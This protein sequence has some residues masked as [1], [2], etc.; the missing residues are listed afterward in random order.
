MAQSPSVDEQQKRTR[1]RGRALEADI[2]KAAWLELGEL[3]WAGFRLDRV[4]A[5]A[6]TG[7]TSVYSRWPDKGSLVRDAGR[8]AAATIRESTLSGE[9]QQDLLA[10]LRG[11]ARHYAGTFGEAMRGLVC[12]TRP[13]AGESDPG[14]L[15]AP[16]QVLVDI[17]SEARRRG[18]LGPR[19]APTRVL[20]LGLVLVSHH[21]LVRAQVPTDEELSEIVSSVWMPLLREATGTPPTA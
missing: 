20:N 11:A 19:R 21:Y 9:L 10:V 17:V 14:G 8:H 18:E 4:A 5:R 3:G 12:S 16:V 15:D 7:R 6:G 2:L 13:G 1:R